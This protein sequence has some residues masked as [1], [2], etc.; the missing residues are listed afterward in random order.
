ME[1]IL[2]KSQFVIDYKIKMGCRITSGVVYS[3]DGLHIALGTQT[4][5]RQIVLGTLPDENNITIWDVNNK[6]LLLTLKGHL[7][8]IICVSYSPDGS[9]IV[10]ASLDKNIIIWDAINGEKLLKLENLSSHIMSVSYSPDG[11][12]IVSGSFDGTIIIWDAIKKSFWNPSKRLLFGTPNNGVLLLKLEGHYDTVTSVSYSPDGSRIVSGSGS[13][14]RGGTIII[15]DVIKGDILLKLNSSFPIISVSYLPDGIRIVS[16]S[17]NKIYIRNAI[18]G[19]VLS[20]LQYDG[21]RINSVSYS[22]DGNCI[23]SGL[24]TMIIILCI[25]QQIKDYIKAQITD[26][27]TSG[28]INIKSM[29]DYFYNLRDKYNNCTMNVKNY[30][31][32]NN[33]QTIR[34]RELNK[35][36]VNMKRSNHLLSFRKK[37]TYKNELGINASGLSREYYDN[38]EIQINLK[39][40]AKEEYKGIK[41]KITESSGQLKILNNLKKD[42]EK[43]DTNRMKN[44]KE[45]LKRLEEEEHK[46]KNIINDIKDYDVIEI[47][48]ILAVSKVN[49]NSI[50]Y[51]NDTIKDIILNKIVSSYNKELDKTVI[52]NILDYM[53]DTNDYI[54][55]KNGKGIL[56][57]SN[58]YLNYTTIEGYDHNN[59]YINKLLTEYNQPS[60]TVYN[61]NKLNKENNSMVNLINSFIYYEIYVDY[62]DFYLSHFVRNLITIQS[63]L[64][65]LYFNFNRD[66]NE[67]EKKEIKLNIKNLFTQFTEEELYLFNK[68]ISG[69][70]NKL[71]KKYRINIEKNNNGK[72]ILPYYHTC[73][74]SVDIYYNSIFREKLLDNK[75]E[76]IKFLELSVGFTM[77]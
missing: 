22:P 77:D 51:I 10:S 61:V 72:L 20:N 2:E 1:N 12:R 18:N 52:K 28:K 55:K 13:G 6:K 26:F 37:I 23:V 39:I 64:N 56:L 58:K 30:Q 11:M 46:L 40:T 53:N 31:N 67:Y 65:N 75:A 62:Y 3:P 41:N 35:L 38:L 14:S 42:R 7:H 9:R 45:V 54:L 68:A 66:Y 70:H 21:D 29:I 44:I 47:L 4:D 8:I 25:K 50:Y 76:F 16:L 32:L 17:D 69:S 60:E 48:K 33:Y 74:V 63:F 43:P 27:K 19:Q 34:D 15:W 24:S 71:S 73:F 59:N 5:V 36:V 49:C 57:K